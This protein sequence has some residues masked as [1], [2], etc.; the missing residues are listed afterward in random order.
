MTKDDSDLS[1]REVA[2]LVGQGKA[3]ARDFESLCPPARKAADVGREVASVASNVAW[4]P[5]RLLWNLLVIVAS[6]TLTALWCSFLI[7]SVLGVVLVLIFLGLDGFL[8][9]L[10]I[11]KLVVPIWR[12]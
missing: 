8:L 7:G 11:M 10:V 6:L 2:W 5:L 12:E 3:T 1:A 9:P 4:L